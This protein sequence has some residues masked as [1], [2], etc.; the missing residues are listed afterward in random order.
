MNYNIIPLVYR[1][2]MFTPEE[3]F[4]YKLHSPVTMYFVSDKDEV[5]HTQEIDNG[6]TKIKLRDKVALIY[7]DTTKKLT[8]DSYITAKTKQVALFAPN[9]LQFET[10]DTKATLVSGYSYTIDSG[11]CLELQ[12]LSFVSNIYS[13]EEHHIKCI[14]NIL[15]L[16]GKETIKELKFRVQGKRP[17]FLNVKVDHSEV[18]GMLINFYS[19]TSTIID[20]ILLHGKERNII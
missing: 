3:I 16:E 9:M 19:S 4:A 15:D 12:S 17:H 7:Y 14:L 20:N 18:A 10:I 2:S 11:A 5:V 13:E 1:N 8:K 6:R